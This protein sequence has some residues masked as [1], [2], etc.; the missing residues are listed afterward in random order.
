LANVD[1]DSG[2]FR[3]FRSSSSVVSGTSRTAARSCSAYVTAAGIDPRR[4]G[5]GPIRP[6]AARRCFRR[7]TQ[8]VLTENFAATADV[9]S[10]ASTS[11]STRSRKSNE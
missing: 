5:V 8:A 4:W 3:R 9:A 11:F 6:V 1:R 10:P 2:Q 7:R